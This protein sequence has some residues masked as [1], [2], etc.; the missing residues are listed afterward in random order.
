[1]LK[2]TNSFYQYLILRLVA[3]SQN[4]ITNIKLFNKQPFYKQLASRIQFKQQYRIPDIPEMF[5]E[6]SAVFLT[7]LNALMLMQMARQ[8]IS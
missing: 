5:S 2:K 6:C 8:Q 4:S 1:M 3:I 7:R